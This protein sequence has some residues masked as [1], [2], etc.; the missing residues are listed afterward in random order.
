MLR[1]KA[2]GERKLEEH[3]SDVPA[4]GTQLPGI[5]LLKIALKGKLRY[6]CMRRV[7]VPLSREDASF[8]RNENAMLLPDGRFYDARCSKSGAFATR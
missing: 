3:I 4:G 5:P 1:E 6:C 2:V 8:H 7:A